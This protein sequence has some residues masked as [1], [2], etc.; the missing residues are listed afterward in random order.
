MRYLW[1]KLFVAVAVALAGARASGALRCTVVADGAMI[2][3]LRRRL[4][5]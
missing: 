5:A 2:H 4:L 3:V 1:F